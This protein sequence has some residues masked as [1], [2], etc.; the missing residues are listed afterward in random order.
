MAPAE[1][2]EAVAAA[3]LDPRPAQVHAVLGDDDVERRVEGHRRAFDGSRR[4]D[5]ASALEA[6]EH[7]APTQN[8][9]REGLTDDAHVHPDIMTPD[10]H[11]PSGRRTLG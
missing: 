8:G 9:W 10:A 3:P 2:E 11:G 5:L 4:L 7:P 6:D 1:V